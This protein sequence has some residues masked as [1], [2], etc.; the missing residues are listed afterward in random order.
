MMR[1]DLPYSL[2]IQAPR[3]PVSR[4]ERRGDSNSTARAPVVLSALEPVTGSSTGFGS[5]PLISYIVGV[6]ADTA[7]TSASAA[8]AY[9]VLDDAGSRAYS[10]AA[11]SGGGVLA[12]RFLRRR[13]KKKT[14]KP[15]S[16]ATGMPTPSPTPRAVVLDSF[17]GSA[18]TG[19]LVAVVPALD[20]DDS[21]ETVTV[22]V[23]EEGVADEGVV[24]KI[25]EVWVCVNDS[26][27][28]VTV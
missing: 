13:K 3:L 4:G 28:M 21:V 20:A 5:S 1:V 8:W 18:S 14:P 22:D 2:K 10:S 19:L 27:M 26:P 9:L 6:V 25:V 11:I 16:A 15:I 23:V 7:G 12:L 17:A 24:E